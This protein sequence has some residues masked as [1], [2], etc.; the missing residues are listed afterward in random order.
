MASL[1][2][3]ERR[4]SKPASAGASS[5][6]VGSS[7]DAHQRPQSRLP[8]K[9]I[10]VHNREDRLMDEGPVTA[11][12]APP[13]DNSMQ[14]FQVLIAEDVAILT[15]SSMP[16]D[17]SDDPNED[18]TSEPQLQ[19]MPPRGHFPPIERDARVHHKVPTI[20]GEASTTRGEKRRNS[21]T[22]IP[23]AN[24]K[25]VRNKQK[26]IRAKK[27]VKLTTLVT[28]CARSDWCNGN[29]IR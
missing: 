23:R 11:N 7:S 26:A 15:D 2:Q 3:R 27:W 28:V 17:T 16:I 22:P 6:R 13:T 18:K 10:G 20:M 24:W 29:L 12:I 8:D 4:L 21:E 25:N 5:G 19:P 9:P 1:I 14:E